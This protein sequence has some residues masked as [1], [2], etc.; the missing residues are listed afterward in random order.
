MNKQTNKQ[1]TKKH[2]HTHTHTH[3]HTYI[4]TH[5]TTRK[6]TL[7]RA[8]LVPQLGQLPECVGQLLDVRTLAHAQLVQVRRGQPLQQRYLRVLVTQR[9]EVE[10][11][12]VE[13]QRDQP[14]LDGDGNGV[15][16]SRVV[17]LAHGLDQLLGHVPAG[18]HVGHADRLQ[19]VQLHAHQERRVVVAVVLELLCDVGVVDLLLLQ[20]IFGALGKLER[21]CKS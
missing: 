9:E 1:Q 16:N 21:A 12:A 11:V 4:H 19:V 17:E 20:E 8:A 18:Q 10:V 13:V 14:L 15:R 2:T 5:T 3:I 6:R 7:W